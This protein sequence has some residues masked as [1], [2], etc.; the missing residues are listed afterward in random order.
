MAILNMRSCS[1]CL[2]RQAKNACLISIGGKIRP[3]PATSLSIT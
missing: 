2:A 1:G 3:M